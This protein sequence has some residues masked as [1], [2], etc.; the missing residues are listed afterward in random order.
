MIN[1]R[2]NNHA[3]ASHFIADQLGRELLTL[4]DVLHLLGDNATAGIVHLGKVAIAIF[5]FP[6]GNPICA[7]AR[8]A[9]SI[10]AVSVL[11]VRGRH[12]CP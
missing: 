3:P 6:A 12:D 8:G 9:G 5:G 2:R 4:R 10:V 11:S 7:A 1:V